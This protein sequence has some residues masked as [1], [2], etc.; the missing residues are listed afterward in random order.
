MVWPGR[1]PVGRDRRYSDVGLTRDDGVA[2]A[3]GEID[4]WHDFP[5]ADWAD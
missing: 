1:R 5:S 4:A 2:Q 3:F